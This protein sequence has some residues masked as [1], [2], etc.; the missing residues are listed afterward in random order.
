M[1]ASTPQ[2]PEPKGA[3]VALTSLEQFET[4]VKRSDVVTCVYAFTSYCPISSSDTVFD[5]YA[6]LAGEVEFGASKVQFLR[7]DV[8]LVPEI[9]K[10]M[11]VR[12]LPLTNV[13]WEGNCLHSVTGGNVDKIK[14]AVRHGC[15]AKYIA[16]TEREKAEKERRAGEEPSAAAPKAGAGRVASKPSTPSGRRSSSTGSRKK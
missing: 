15:Q 7:Y 9:T 3:V 8:A 16:V 5:G 14:L 4:E 13:Y 2:S 1:S 6:G 11:S 10:A 12:A